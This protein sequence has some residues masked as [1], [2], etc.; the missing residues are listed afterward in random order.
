MLSKTYGISDT[1][2]VYIYKTESSHRNQRLVCGTTDLMKQ[3]TVRPGRLG[4][5]A[6]RICL[7][8][9][10]Y[11]TPLSIRLFWIYSINTPKPESMSIP[12]DEAT[13]TFLQQG[14]RG[15]FWILPLSLAQSVE[16]NSHH[17]L[18]NLL[19]NRLDLIQCQISLWCYQ[20]ST[21]L[22]RYL[23][24]W[25][26]PNRHLYH[27]IFILRNMLNF[28]P[29]YANTNLFIIIW[30]IDNHLHSFTIWWSFTQLAIL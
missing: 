12:V 30:F 11:Y 26:P 3:D 16:P 10:A 13:L 1:W 28:P 19:Q 22:F 8:K 23:K 20:W 29:R 27:A 9:L 4:L 6:L 17:A 25:H 15:C 18:R 24:T 21:F 5:I 14:R 2:K 7:S